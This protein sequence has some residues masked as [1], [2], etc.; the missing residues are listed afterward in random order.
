MRHGSSLVLSA[1]VCAAMASVRVAVAQGPD[2][3]HSNIQDS[4]RYPSTGGPVNG[5]YGYAWGSY[6]CNI[7][8]AN[9]SWI[10]G[11]TPAL[12]M[13]AYRLYNGRFM[14]IGIGH[15]KHGC[16]VG[17]GAGCGLT[18]STVG[19]GLRAG[20]QD[21]YSAGFNG[22]TTRLGPRSGIDPYAGTF[23]A[24]AAGTGDA[25]WRHV[26][27]N[28]S[29]MDPVNFPGARYFAEGEYVCAEELPAAKLNNASYRPANIANT[30]TSPTYAWT[31]TGSTAVGR[32]AIYA[33]RDH[34]LGLNMIDPS[35]SVVNADVPGEGRFV[36]AG[37]VTDLGNGTWRY[38]Y[39]V[40]NLDS[41]RSGGGFSIP[42]RPGAVV[43]DIGFNSVPYHSGEPYDNSPWTSQ[44]SLDR[45]VFSSPAK[46]EGNPN[47]NALRWGTMYNFW[48]TANIPPSA[49]LGS[50]AL[51]L[52]IPGTPASISIDGLPV[53][54]PPAACAA[55]FDHSGM[56]AVQDIFA[57]V[58]AWFAQE[59]R[60]DWNGQNGLTEQDIFDYLGAW[61][62]GC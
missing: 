35:V 54:T 29:D 46:Y 61:F 41:H 5:K 31:M 8:T 37:K 24:I 7:G 2:I 33:W 1:M 13:N 28:V 38:D 12:A 32:P 17:N 50:A 18:C 51:D 55:D 25:I 30:G 62:V 34:G 45:V 27:I 6:T 16:C 21:I 58:A 48:F 47:T 10:N 19:T 52:F 56:L 44:R 3:T 15:C 53:P 26:Q 23:T 36:G 11:G 39:A 42:V 20:C 43:T 59:P 14:Q 9:L 4:A 40:F 22:G 49:T 57:F 60:A